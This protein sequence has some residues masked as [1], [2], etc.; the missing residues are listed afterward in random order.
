MSRQ[1]RLQSER[2]AI[3]IH[4]AFALMALLVF[5]SFV[6]DYGVM[7][8]SRRQAQNVVDSAALAGALALMWGGSPTQAAQHFAAVNPI[9]GQGNSA[10]NV[11]VTLSGRHHGYSAVPH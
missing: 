2:G 9:W 5:T 10:A 8:V 3:I 4:V 11:D 7:W 6:I 1:S